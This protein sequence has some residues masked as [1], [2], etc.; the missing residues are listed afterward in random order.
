MSEEN[1]SQDRAE[2][3]EDSQAENPKINPD[4]LEYE[5]IYPPYHVFEDTEEEHRIFAELVQRR[6]EGIEQPPEDPQV[7][8]YLES[9]NS[10]LDA[11]VPQIDTRK[12][13][14]VVLTPLV[15]ADALTALLAMSNIEA[16]VVPTSTG[17]VA[18][19]EVP[20]K[21]TDDI[22]SLLGA[23]RPMPAE[24]EALAASISNF[25]RMGAVLLVSWLVEGDAVE[26]GVSGQITARRYMG[27]KPETDLPA[28]LVIS[29]LDQ[30]VEDL[31][32]GRVSAADLSDLDSSKTSRLRALRILAKNLRR[33]KH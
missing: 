23:A 11:P 21:V 20:V 6:K 3:P 4:D 25:S 31:L 5:E 9:L 19:L 22:E 26:P 18:C 2:N 14:A 8:Q 1:R 33:G 17:A 32:L 12:T 15:D 29:G 27:G 7:Q 24:A 28:G 10:E 16:A 13:V 30:R